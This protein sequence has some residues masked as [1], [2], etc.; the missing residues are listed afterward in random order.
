[1]QDATEAFDC[2]NEDHLRVFAEVFVCGDTDTDVARKVSKKL[3]LTKPLNARN[4]VNLLLRKGFSDKLKRHQPEVKV[5]TAMRVRT[6]RS[7]YAAK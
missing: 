1:M 7:G 6:Q 5:D 4:V 2:E 3:K